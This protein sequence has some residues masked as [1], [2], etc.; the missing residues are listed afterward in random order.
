MSGPTLLTEPE[1][2]A[3]IGMSVAY[4]R[5]DRCRG[6]LTG[7]TPGPPYLRLGRSIR[8]DTHDLDAWL[9]ARRVARGAA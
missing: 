1:A 6:H 5:M 4:L 8:Y 2:A 9:G 3:Y 7:R